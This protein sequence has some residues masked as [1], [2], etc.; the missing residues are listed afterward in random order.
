MVQSKNPT[1]KSFE[2]LFLTDANFDNL[3]GDE[4]DRKNATTAST[5]NTPMEHRGKPGKCE[6]VEFDM[7]DSAWIYGRRNQFTVR[8]K[9]LFKRVVNNLCFYKTR[10]Y[11]I[12]QA[13]LITMQTPAKD[14]VKSVAD[15]AL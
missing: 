5:R 4:L 12:E 7:A 1:S 15:P 6:Q 10:H 11:T 8:D 9:Q 13:D 14:S 3:L 2:E